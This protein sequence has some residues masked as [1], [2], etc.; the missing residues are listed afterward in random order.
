VI[1]KHLFTYF[2]YENMHKDV[3]LYY[4]GISQKYI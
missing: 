1:Q 4:C 2:V 3:V